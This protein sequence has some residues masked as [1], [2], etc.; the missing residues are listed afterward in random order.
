MMIQI[1]NESQSVT[2]MESSDD[3]VRELFVDNHDKYFNRQG[4]LRKE[5]IDELGQDGIIKLFNAVCDKYRPFR[6][7]QAKV[8]SK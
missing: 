6:Q 8:E 3:I 4:N 2:D 5:M 7:N 1:V